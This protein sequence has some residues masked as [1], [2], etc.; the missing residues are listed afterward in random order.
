VQ[1][2]LYFWTTILAPSDDPAR[3]NTIDLVG[4]VGLRRLRPDASCQLSGIGW[5]DQTNPT[6]TPRR[7]EPLLPLTGELCGLEPMV[8]DFCSRPIPAVRRAPDVEG[9]ARI[10][11][12]PGPVGASGAATCVSAELTRSAG[13]RVPRPDKPEVHFSKQVAEPIERFMR[14]ILVDR[15]LWPTLSARVRVYSALEPRL[16]Q[17]SRRDEDLLPV[18]CTVERRGVGLLAAECGAYAQYQPLL[19]WACERVGWNPERF[20]V[21]RLSLPYPPMPSTV[22]VSIRPSPT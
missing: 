8:P 13:G 10:D 3:V 4:Q 17:A 22:V 16:D 20:A 18:S 12:V 2:A 21:W 6:A 9:Q 15:E 11:L 14:D 7:A 1:T 5:R 19:R